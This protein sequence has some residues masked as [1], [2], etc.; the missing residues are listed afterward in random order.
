MQHENA[1]TNQDAID[2]IAAEYRG[3]LR[4]G[5]RPPVAEYLERH[6]ELRQQL[7]ELLPALGAAAAIDASPVG[8]ED[9]M[10]CPGVRDAD[11]QSRNSGFPQIPNYRL[12]REIGR[13]GMGIVYEAEHTLLGRHVALKVLPAHLSSN[14]TAVKRF[15]LEARAAA[16][17]HH[18]NIV[19]VF[20][21]GCTD[22]Y[23]YYAM[24]FI[25]GDGLDRV[26]DVIRDQRGICDQHIP[27]QPVRSQ[28][29]AAAS[30]AITA[31]STVPQRV[32]TRS[33]DTKRP[34]TAKLSNT[35]SLNSSLDVSHAYARH[36][37]KIGTEVAA[38]LDHAHGRGIIH[39]DIKPSNILLDTDGRAW[40]ADFGLA[41]SDSV[42][43]T[44]TG[45]ILG[46]LR[47][48]SP[49]R[50]SGPCD[51]RGDVYG[52]GATL[53][54]MLTLRPLF[55]ADDHLALIDRIKTE[56]PRPIREID[57]TIPAD[58]ETIVHKALEKDPARRY[59]TARQLAEDLQ[60]FLEGRPIHARR[61]GPLERLGLWAKNNKLVATLAASLLIGVVATAV[62]ATVGALV[63]RDM[64]RNAE[65]QAA[66]AIASAKR[67]TDVLEIVRA[68]FNRTNPNSGASA[69]TSAREVLVEA[70][71]R[72]DASG[73]DDDGRIEL[74]ATLASCFYGLGDFEAVLP[75]REQEAM[76]QTKRW[77][78]E[79]LETLISQENLAVAYAALGR[80]DEAIP[81]FES[82]LES[83]SARLGSQDLRTLSCLN[84]FAAALVEFGRLEDAL[85]L[86][87]TA[88]AA[89]KGN[90]GDTH[91][92]TLE[93]MNNLAALLAKL[94]RISDA[95]PLYEKVL[96][97]SR[98]NTGEDDPGTIRAMNNL[99]SAYDAAGRPD[100]ALPLYEQA[101][102]ACK[103]R[104]GPT[105]PYTLGA[106]NNL[107][108][109]CLAAGRSDQ[110]LPLYE[111]AFAALNNTLGP[112]H[113]ATLIVTNNLAHVYE[114]QGRLDTA[115][116]LFERV[117]ATQTKTLGVDHPSTLNSMNLLAGAY[118][119]AGRL[120]EAV[121]L[122]EETL[123][124]RT[125]KLGV[126]HP[127]T[128]ISMN[129][130]A[131][132]YKAVGRIA[133]SLPIYAE[134]LALR[135]KK[136][137]P[138]HPDT[139]TSMTSLASAFDT[140]G[141]LDDALPLYQEALTAYQAKFGLEHPL[142]LE[143]MT[144]LASAL[145][146]V[147][148]ADEAEPLFRTSLET[149]QRIT[150]DD[151]KVFATQ[152]AL[153]ETLMRQERIEDALRYLEKGYEGLRQR[154]APVPILKT[155]LE[156]LIRWAQLQKDEDAIARWL[157]ELASLD[158]PG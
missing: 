66:E 83:L 148:R 85:P 9:T 60:R 14:D 103:V 146:W 156:R 114:S 124:L 59:A 133:D 115:L 138:E 17:M 45:N 50:F 7:L 132:V 63:Y 143:T 16:A 152:S 37:A 65:Q 18:S 153:G 11:A 137:G 141:R 51:A 20:D 131:F 108:G 71:K 49:E 128:L 142:T 86:L 81:L 53:Y 15:A 121:R 127:D 79:H 144:T 22:E 158:K 43:L 90:L 151:W 157:A 135:R 136:L 42:E 155:S 1:A 55:A 40:V 129:N 75:L 27:G 44:R 31:D 74:L 82:V 109:A 67:A 113:P 111:E 32:S 70:R 97:A 76:L 106:L 73:L 12:V 58:L 118:E 92:D 94:G 39:R 119:S 30:R 69:E 4:R 3:R 19:P 47:Y 38:A 52:L 21:V 125:A 10:A 98:A 95:I 100:E 120:E 34:S 147:G 134:T 107:A 112:D 29:A 62:A 150:P 36:V 35:S 77:G 126:D 122:Y 25:V 57:R 78:A 64:A 48:M 91:A 2:S 104:L 5:E 99:A 123:R 61:V 110:A 33:N 8:D 13:G 68:S 88:L 93:T 101:L 41:K 96:S 139:L 149:R 87:E 117:L 130:L 46:T 105:H 6:P 72:L 23:N 56:S 54:E 26:I 102:A 145:L 80:F 140:A 89:R 84:N 154:D 24:Q 116:P 28:A